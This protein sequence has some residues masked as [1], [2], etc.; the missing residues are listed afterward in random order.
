MSKYEETWTPIS[1]SRSVLNADQTS[2]KMLC[3]IANELHS[4]EM[5][6]GVIS[7]NIKKRK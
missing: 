4:I 6:L 3:A 2:A 1:G 7:N 5:H